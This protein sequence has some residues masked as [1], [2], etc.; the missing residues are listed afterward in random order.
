MRS[1]PTRARRCFETQAAHIQRIA[2]RALRHAWQSA[3][4][5]GSLATSLVERRWARRGR[6]I[7]V[8]RERARECARERARERARVRVGVT[9]LPVP[10]VVVGWSCGASADSHDT[11]GAVWRSVHVALRACGA[12]FRDESTWR[13]RVLCDD[14]QSSCMWPCALRRQV[15]GAMDYKTRPATA[16]STQPT[17]THAQVPL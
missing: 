4:C 17:H 5:L 10:C 7:V 14:G 3:L 16:V 9:L 6:V 1:R 2:G 8:A 11:N 15:G 12:P 13:A